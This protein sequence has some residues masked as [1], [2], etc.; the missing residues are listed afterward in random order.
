MA[1]AGNPNITD[2]G[3]DT[4]WQPGQSGN[5]S[6]RKPNIFKK[7]KL[8]YEFTKQDL[9]NVIVSLLL[10]P[11]KELAKLN[12]NPSTP[13]FMKVIISGIMH[14]RKRGDIKVT[15]PLLDRV[16]GKAKESHEHSGNMNVTANLPVEERDKRLSE[17]LEK[18]GLNQNT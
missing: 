8:D 5:P 4:Q 11:D 2:I 13:V 1:E 17:L 10:K 14:D 15:N 16:Y 6:G 7:L 18:H 3:K 9:E 12:K